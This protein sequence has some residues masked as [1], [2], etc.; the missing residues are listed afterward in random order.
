M[1]I[2]L[3]KMLLLC[4]LLFA[5]IG[6]SV[7]MNICVLRFYKYKGDEAAALRLSERLNKYVKPLCLVLLLGAAALLNHEAIGHFLMTMDRVTMLV[8]T[9]FVYAIAFLNEIFSKMTTAP[10]LQALGRDADVDVQGVFRTT[11]LFLR[12]LVPLLLLNAVIAVWPIVV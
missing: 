12:M 5:G 1:F 11:K 10:M 2:L 3:G 9:L 6:V 4:P 7:C 8:L